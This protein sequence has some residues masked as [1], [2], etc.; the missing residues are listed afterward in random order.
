MGKDSDKKPLA[1]AHGASL[2]QDFDDRTTLP[3]ILQ[4]AAKTNQGIIYLAQDGTEL[5]QS[6]AEL[7]DLAGRLLGGLRALGLK[8]QDKVILNLFPYHILI[9]LPYYFHIILLLF[10]YY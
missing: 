8:P 6:Y 3:E 7:L 10:S 4:R 1:I 5:F 2:S 9:L